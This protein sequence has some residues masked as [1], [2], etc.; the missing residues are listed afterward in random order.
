MNCSSLNANFL[1]SSRLLALWGKG[2][3]CLMLMSISSTH[4]LIENSQA[5]IDAYG[6]N[7]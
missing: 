1:L 5:F 6:M 3:V 7:K 4:M 2:C